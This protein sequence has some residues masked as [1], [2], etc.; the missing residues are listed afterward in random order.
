M[1]KPNIER[2]M[3]TAI[4]T[5][6][7]G[8]DGSYLVEFLLEKGYK[9]YGTK[10][11]A[12]DLGLD[13][14]KNVIDNLNLE[15]REIDITDPF[16]VSSFIKEIQPDEFYNLAAQSHVK[17][18]FET[19]AQTFSVNAL[20]VLNILEAIRTQSPHTRLY[21]ASTSE[22]FGQVVESP[23][24]ETTP[25]YPRS[26]YGVSK[27]A[28]HWMVKNYRESY[29]LYACCGILFNHESERRGENFV[30]QKI[31]KAVARIKAGLQK[32]VELGNLDS[33]RDWGYAPEFVEGMWMMLQQ[34]EPVDLV[35]ATG[36]THTIREFLE[37]CFTYAGLGDYR[38]Y[39]VVNP[40][41]FRPAEV[42]VL[43]GDPSKAIEVLNWRASVDVKRLAEKMTQHQ[44]D[45]L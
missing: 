10:R 3:K 28:A 20:A 45:K 32:N 40:K 44:I 17:V 34:E 13:N 25:F 21:Q 19:P 6:A 1:D 22:L 41:F 8:Q 5:G 27:L 15:L 9:V 24:R 36:V 31:A 37:H 12:N 11:R 4:V 42:E 18:S 43:L 38:K 26:P 35:L 23:Q 7:T 2:N 16:G 33:K 29:G 30:T 39:V 14:L